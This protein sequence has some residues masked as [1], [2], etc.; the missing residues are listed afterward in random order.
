MRFKDQMNL[1]SLI[2]VHCSEK[3]IQATIFSSPSTFVLSATHTRLALCVLKRICS[4]KLSSMEQAF[5]LA[6]FPF[7]CE[8]G[9]AATQHIQLTTETRPK[10]ALP[11]QSNRSRMKFRSF[12]VLFLTLTNTSTAFA[13]VGEF[14]MCHRTLHTSKAY[15][16]S[17]FWRSSDEGRTKLSTKIHSSRVWSGYNVIGCKKRERERAAGTST[18]SI[19]SLLVTQGLIVVTSLVVGYKL[20]LLQ[21]RRGGRAVM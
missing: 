13:G 8:G 16:H 5:I 10:T 9:I 1:N 6:L 11:W 19:S 17:N 20:N 4:W 18:F 15:Q 7:P 3:K 21:G 12:F 2:F 14:P